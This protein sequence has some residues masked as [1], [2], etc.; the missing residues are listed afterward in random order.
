MVMLY[1][2]ND[3]LRRMRGSVITCEHRYNFDKMIIKRQ[4]KG[5]SSPE[6]I[7]IAC[8]HCVSFVSVT[9]VFSHRITD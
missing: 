2:R 1:K 7:E 5:K 9:W 6:T 8:D 4:E 3:D